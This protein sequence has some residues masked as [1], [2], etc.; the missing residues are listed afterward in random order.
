MELREGLL[1]HG[2]HL[3]HG[4]PHRAR[5]PAAA[6]EPA[7]SLVGCGLPDDVDRVRI[8][9]VRRRV[10]LHQVRVQLLVAGRRSR[11]WRGP[12]PVRELR[13]PPHDPGRGDAALRPRG[14]RLRRLAMG[15]PLAPSM[16]ARAATG[17]RKPASTSAPALS[18]TALTYL[19]PFSYSAPSSSSARRDAACPSAGPTPLYALLDGA[20]TGICPPDSPHPALRA[21]RG[22]DGSTPIGRVPARQASSTPPSTA[23][24]WPV[25]KAAAS[26][27]RYTAAAPVS[28]ESAVCRC[29][30]VGR[31]MARSSSPRVAAT[32]AKTPSGCHRL[33]EL[34]SRSG[35][36]GSVP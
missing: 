17:N 19:D 10:N 1:R 26:E 34:T 36:S 6:P 4:D 33:P 9:G 15:A 13:P 20:R 31:P 5:H 28:D 29:I 30:T 32:R 3:V 8:L 22:S 18:L 24:T 7:G 35:S 16:M 2:A 11:K 14:Q 23:R 25:T 27:A 12:G 21:P